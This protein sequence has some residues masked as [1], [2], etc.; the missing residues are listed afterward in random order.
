MNF[1]TLVRKEL[2]LE[3]KDISRLISTFV[4]IIKKTIV[5]GI[6]STPFFIE[7]KSSRANIK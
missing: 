3:V 5:D 4:K 6:L 2:R 7:L 1:Y